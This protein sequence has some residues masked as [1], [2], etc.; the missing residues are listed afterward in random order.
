MGCKYQLKFLGYFL[1]FIHTCFCT[2]FTNVR[3]FYFSKTQVPMYCSTSPQQALG[4]SV[5]HTWG[6]GVTCV[7]ALGSRN[8]LQM[9]AVIITSVCVAGKGL[10]NQAC[11]CPLGP[12]LHT[13]CSAI[14]EAGK[15]KVGAKHAE[16]TQAKRGHYR[17]GIFMRWTFPL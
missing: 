7:C 9:C 16:L 15:E 6:G 3:P 8:W 11:G 12:G 4:L 14:T 17:S 10:A 5:S 13:T 1:S 2:P